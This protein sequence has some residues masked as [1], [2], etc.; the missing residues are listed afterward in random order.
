MKISPTSLIMTLGLEHE[1]GP[2]EL[3]ELRAIYKDEVADLGNRAIKEA[4][5]SARYSPTRGDLPKKSAM[6]ELR[7][8]QVLNKTS[9]IS[10]GNKMDGMLRGLLEEVPAE[11]AEHAFTHLLMDINR[12]MLDINPMSPCDVSDEDLGFAR[13]VLAAYVNSYHEVSCQPDGTDIRKIMMH[14]RVSLK[15]FIERRLE[16]MDA[17]FAVINDAG[18]VAAGVVLLEEQAL[19]ELD[20]SLQE[21]MKSA[22][23]E[24]LGPFAGV[25]LGE[26]VKQTI[27]SGEVGAS[28]D[29]FT[30]N[31]ESHDGKCKFH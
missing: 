15:L 17:A 5:R 6:E 7:E 21:E 24:I 25:I 18:D 4:K 27:A 2:N 9:L 19:K 22:L 14:M 13:W 12:V 11:H 28:K 26:E 31:P 23:Q 20:A 30:I 1:L 8:M 10:I 29:S 16:F 3:R